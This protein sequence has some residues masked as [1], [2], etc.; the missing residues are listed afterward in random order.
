M[1]NKWVNFKQVQGCILGDIYANQLH[2]SQESKEM[3]LHPTDLVLKIIDPSTLNFWYWR[4]SWFEDEQ[5]NDHLI[6]LEQ[7]T[8]EPLKYRSE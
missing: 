7:D 4:I 6:I 8:P 2:V 3:V 5:S 1:K